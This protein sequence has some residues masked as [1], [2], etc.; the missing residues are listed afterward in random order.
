M[1]GY[2][3]T[4]PARDECKVFHPAGGGLNYL[5]PEET[6]MDNLF[7]SEVVYQTWYANEN[8]AVGG[9]GN[10]R[11]SSGECQ[12]GVPDCNELM[13]GVPYIK[14]E[15]CLAINKKLNSGHNNSGDPYIDQDFS[16]ATFGGTQGKFR[17]G[18][19]DTVINM[20]IGSP[21]NY[22]NLM[23]GCIEGDLNPPAG[24]YS[25]FQVLIVR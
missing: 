13:I 20:G 3:H 16:F 22:R 19:G 10:S 17:G 24:T 18:Y 1:A 4:P 8:N 23:A 14:K 5:T 25:F 12:S 2:E 15:I 21:A 11:G 7:S 9:L 6:W